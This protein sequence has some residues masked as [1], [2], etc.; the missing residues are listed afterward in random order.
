MQQSSYNPRLISFPR[1]GSI[2]T[3]H[4]RRI[5][6][7]AV[8]SIVGVEPSDRRYVERLLGPTSDQLGNRRW[9]LDLE[10]GN[11]AMEPIEI[12]PPSLSTPSFHQDCYI[13]GP[14]KGSLA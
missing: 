4:L 14:S 3:F 12:L 9:I 1:R 10:E 11:H 7:L 13:P 8:P 6:S 2:G 5:F